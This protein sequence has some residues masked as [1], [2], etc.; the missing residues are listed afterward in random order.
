[1]AQRACGILESLDTAT[2]I[3][4][5]MEK[6]TQRL[7]WVIVL[8]AFG[9]FCSVC[10]G[11]TTGIYFFFFESTVALD[12]VLHV[13]R[14]TAV[15][16]T[17]DL[18]ERGI[19]GQDAY[20]LVNRPA[21]ISTDS[22]SQFT[23]SFYV[24]DENQVPQLVAAVTLKNTSAFTLRRANRPRFQWSNGRYEI[25][26]QNFTGEMDVVVLGAP[27]RSLLMRIYTQRDELVY[28]NQPGRYMLS[29][30]DIY[31]HTANRAGEAILFSANRESNLLIP[32][33]QEG[34]IFVGRSPVFYPA[35]VNLLENSL[36]VFDMPAP[37]E[38]G[39]TALPGRWGCANIQADLPRGVYLPGTIDGRLALRLRRA[40]DASTNGETRCKQPFAGDGK[41]VSQFNYLEL[42]TTFYLNYQSLS[43]CGIEGSECALMLHLQ[44]VDTNGVPREWYQGFYYNLNPAFDFYKQRCASC[45]QDHLQVNEKTWYTFETGNLFNVLPADA[46]PAAITN[47]EFYASGHQYDTFI[48]DIALY[49]GFVDAAVPVSGV[50]QTGN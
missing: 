24:T 15:I 23:V 10:V 48:S 12:A 21:Q 2:Y 18:A 50:P 5:D 41:A 35:R 29:A 46:R 20:T 8:V 6:Q 14:G 34:R 37:S 32:A 39:V 31:F 45:M 42:E 40:E 11:S 16:T 33:G 28:I 27:Q 1:M 43:E 3:T 44:Y 13:G 49:A 26:L 38:D 36:F 47:V 17:Q 25:E 22:Q 7:A 9:V 30:N 4:P 19:R